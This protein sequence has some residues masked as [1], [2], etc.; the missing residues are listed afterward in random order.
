M[1]DLRNGQVLYNDGSSDM[2]VSTA[3]GPAPR[4]KFTV[5]KSTPKGKSTLVVVANGIASS[6][7]GVTIS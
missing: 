6:S 7:S 3:L 5:P 1:L 4:P 2:E